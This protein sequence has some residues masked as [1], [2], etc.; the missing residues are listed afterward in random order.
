MSIG[1]D[2]YLGGGA[3]AGYYVSPMREEAGHEPIDEALA[4]DEQA[5]ID[6]STYIKPFKQ[7]SIYG[8]L[9][10]ATGSKDIVSRRPF[11]ARPNAPHW[12]QVG[13]KLDF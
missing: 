5:W 11:G 4:T 7:L 9:R 6:F 3:I 1:V 8:N 2:T 10:N 13:V 12:L